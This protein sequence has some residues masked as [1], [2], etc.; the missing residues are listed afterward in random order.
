M[1]FQS[2]FCIIFPLKYHQ[3]YTFKNRLRTT[4]FYAF[5]QSAQYDV[6]ALEITLSKTNDFR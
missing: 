2:Y 6:Y 3:K 5:R 4:S 1:L